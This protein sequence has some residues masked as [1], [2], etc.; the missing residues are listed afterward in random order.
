M[1]FWFNMDD[2]VNNLDNLDFSFEIE[3]LTNE[4][5][6]SFVAGLINRSVSMDALMKVIF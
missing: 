3:D 1:F 2:I 4:N 6:D 5:Q